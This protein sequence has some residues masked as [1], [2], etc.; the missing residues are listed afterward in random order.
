MLLLGWL[1]RHCNVVSR[2]WLQYVIT[3]MA[4]EMIGIVFNIIN[5]PFERNFISNRNGKTLG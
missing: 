3:V 5:T 2:V 4:D 1:S